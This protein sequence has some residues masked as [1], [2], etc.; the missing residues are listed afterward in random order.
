MLFT[1]MTFIGIDPTAGKRPITYAAVDDN[2]QILALGEGNLDDVVAFTAGQQH[3]YVALSAPRQP[4]TGIMAKP[5]IRQAL[6]PTP[7]PG[8]WTNFRL[9]EYLIRQHNLHIPRTPGKDERAPNWMQMSYHLFQRLDNLGYVRLGREA[10]ERCTLEVYP[11]ACFSAM[12]GIIPF[13]K[14]T[15][16]G[17][18]QRQLILFDAGLEIPDPM[19]F[20]EEIT[21]SRLLRGVL[22]T[23]ILYTSAELD[24]LVA[25]YTAWMCAKQPDQVS[26]FGDVDEGEIIV[27]VRN[28]K[29]RYS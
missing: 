8:R 19:H 2:L 27:P 10:A 29:Q 9:C 24:A 16:E 7:V 23:G 3:T 5:E 21:R 25:A 14:A 15:L 17:R 6:S 12:L 13:Y 18:L 20:F 26:V 28:L 1:Q 4:N 11:H 22:P